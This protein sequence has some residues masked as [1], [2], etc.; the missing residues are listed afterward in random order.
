V[1]APGSVELVL[2]AHNEEE[3]IGRTVGDFLAVADVDVLVAEDGSSD[4]TRAVVEALAANGRVRLTPHAPRK[5]YSR[6]V[7]D[8]AA[9]TTAEIVVFCDGD[10]Q[11]RPSD[12]VRLVAALEP[13]A[14]VAGARSPRRDSRFR[15]LASRAFGVVYRLL[16]PVRMRDPSSP[17]VAAFRSDLET[18][19]PVRP[20]LPQG[21]WWEFFARAEAAGLSI[22]EVP[23]EHRA[24]E[25][26]RTQVYRLRRLPRIVLEHLVGL[27]RL[28]RELRRVRTAR[29]AALPI[30]PTRVAKPR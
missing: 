3:T 15:T 29:A 10:G 2:V 1:V 8:A 25:A 9:G 5:G 11:Y 19:L 6:A 26:G 21:F 24:R 23:V 4:A 20:L 28:R 17:F 30:V 7:T 27:F 18:L 22:V 16:V 13:G 14:V 12:L